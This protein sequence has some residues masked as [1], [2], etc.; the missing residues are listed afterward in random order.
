[1]HDLTYTNLQNEVEHLR[2]VCARLRNDVEHLRTVC[3]G[4]ESEIDRLRDELDAYHNQRGADV[5][6]I[7]GLKIQKDE[8]ACRGAEELARLRDI[9]EQMLA[10]IGHGGN[11]YCGDNRLTSGTVDLALAALDPAWGDYDPLGRDALAPHPEGKG[12][13]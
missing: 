11:K 1:M 2:A 6:R 4:Q 8:A 10:E 3:V 9:I 12:E 13:R 5:A 7:M